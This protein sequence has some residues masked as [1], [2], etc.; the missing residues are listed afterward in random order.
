MPLKRRLPKRGFHNIFKRRYAVVNIKDLVK[1]EQGSVVDIQAIRAAGI[2]KS[3]SPGIKLLGE[4]TISYPLT[5]K[6]HACSNAA[7][8]KI[9]AAGGHVETINI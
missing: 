1:F 4:G 2:A 5:V 7:R 6:V 8:E 3:S 9:E